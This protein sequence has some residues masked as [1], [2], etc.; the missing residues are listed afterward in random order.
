MTARALMIMGTGSDVGKSLIAA[1]LCRIFADRGLK[2]M[3]RLCARDDFQGPAGAIFAV[4]ELKARKL[5][6][7]DDGTT[8]PRGAADEAEKQAKSMGATVLRYVIR[9]GYRPGL[10]QRLELPSVGPAVP[11]GPVAGQAPHQRAAA[12][13]S[14]HPVIVNSAHIV[15]MQET[16]EA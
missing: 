6:I 5:A 16:S 13:L 2:V 9:A 10:Q 15:E 7:V 8:G 4:N 3:N 11:I 12:T 1:G 14:R